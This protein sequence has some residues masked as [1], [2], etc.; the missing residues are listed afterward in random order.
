MNS[1]YIKILSL[2]HVWLCDPMDCNMQSFP[3]FHRLPELAQTHVHWVGDAIQSSHPLS[4]FSLP[5]LT[6]SQHQSLF[7]MS[8]LFV[9]GGQSIEVSAFAS[10]LPMHIQSW[11]RVDSFRIDWFDLAVQRTLKCA[12]SAFIVTSITIIIIITLSTEIIL[13]TE[14]NRLSP[15]S[16]HVRLELLI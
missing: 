6:L 8:W 16:K 2:S 5:A 13:S 10:V 4:I 12:L 9:L 1:G 14:L 15:L 7:P 11:F 3:A